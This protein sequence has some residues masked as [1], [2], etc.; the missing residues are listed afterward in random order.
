MNLKQILATLCIGSLAA[1][2]L[3]DDAHHPEQ[4]PPAAPSKPAAKAAPGMTDMSGMQANMKRMQEQMA[5]I[6]AASDPKEREQLVNEHMK[7][8][9]ESMSMMHAMMVGLGGMGPR[10]RMDMMEKR[11]DMMQMMM[12]QMM[13]HDAAQQKAK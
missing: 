3:A 10:E 11:M 8:M 6:R 4:Q 13:E 7:T 2:A 12:Q 9:Q 5:Q 1:V